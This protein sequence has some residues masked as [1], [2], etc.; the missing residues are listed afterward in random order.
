MNISNRI[1]FDFRAFLKF[2]PFNSVKNKYNY[3]CQI[4]SKILYS[5]QTC[6][7][8]RCVISFDIKEISAAKH[9]PPGKHTGYPEVPLI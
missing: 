1:Q 5:T 2:N 3:L 4:T 9:G 7:A 6:F 8:S